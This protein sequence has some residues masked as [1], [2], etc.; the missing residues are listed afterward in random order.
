MYQYE[1]FLPKLVQS[2]VRIDERPDTLNMRKGGLFFYLWA[3]F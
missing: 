1:M 3:L 2:S